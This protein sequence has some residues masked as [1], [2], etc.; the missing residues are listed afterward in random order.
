MY[1]KVNKTSKS[2]D[3]QITSLV[4]N[5]FGLVVGIVYDINTTK[6]DKIAE[7]ITLKSKGGASYIQGEL[8]SINVKQLELFEGTITLSNEEIRD[9]TE[10]EEEE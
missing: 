3:I 2:K 9:I 1:T 5:H 8:L 10:Y 7:I 4:S 6:K